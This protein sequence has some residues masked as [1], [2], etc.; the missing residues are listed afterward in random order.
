MFLSSWSI[1]I[2]KD[3]SYQKYKKSDNEIF[4]FLN[5]QMTLWGYQVDLDVHVYSNVHVTLSIH[6]KKKSN[7]V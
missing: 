7:R 3:L 2:E 4:F 6:V 1:S 5:K